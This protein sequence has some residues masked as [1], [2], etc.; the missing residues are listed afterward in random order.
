M[1]TPIDI[2]SSVALVT[3]ANRGLGAAFVQALRAAGAKKVYAAARDRAKVAETEGVV[4][5]QLDVTNPKEVAQAAIACGDVNLLLNNAGIVHLVSPLDPASLDVARLEWE[6]NV[7]G[8]LRLIQT[9]APILAKN[10]GG[11]ILNVLSVLTWLSV[12]GG[13][14]TY[15]ASKA[16]LWSLTNSLRIELAT[17]KTLVAALHVGFMDTDMTSG[18]QVPK[19]SPADVARY[20]VTEL[21][22]GSLE[23][24]ADGISREV[25]QGLSSGVYLSPPKQG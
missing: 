12:P 20:A 6:T 7:V 15:S 17:Q 1:T 25:K 18:M 2:R 9:F 24:L 16:A 3:G 8:P 5:L 11:A 14:A 13:P 23:I 21:Q 22:T 19:V 4:P 10:G